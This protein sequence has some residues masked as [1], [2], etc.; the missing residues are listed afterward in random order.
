MS[1]KN[2]SL[3]CTAVV[4]WFV[5]HTAGASQGTDRDKTAW[6]Q[7]MAHMEKA[8]EHYGQHLDDMAD[9]AILHDMSLADFHFVAHTSEISGTGADRLNRMAHLLSTYGGTVRYETAEADATLVNQRL[10]H[11]KE[12][13]KVAGC[14]MDRV[15]VKTMISGGRGMPARDAIEINE[16]G[17][18]NQSA[19]GA[20]ATGSFM[21]PATPTG[22]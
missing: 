2:R 15:Q 13:L 5:C 8:K 6:Q 4:V 11:V 1:N 12:Y 19:T 21:A 16:R 18:V 10:D 17:P 22:R 14:D 9:N 20:G 3:V 7:Q